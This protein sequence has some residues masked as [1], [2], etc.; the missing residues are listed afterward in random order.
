MIM[1]HG[2]NTCSGYTRSKVTRD[3]TICD[4]RE[5]SLSHG[6]SIM[7]PLSTVCRDAPFRGPVVNCES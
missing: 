4:P 5:I 3:L 7:C 6:R 2:W 1:G